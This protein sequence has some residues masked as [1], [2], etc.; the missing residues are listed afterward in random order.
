MD[1]LRNN[2]FLKHF[3]KTLFF[4]IRRVESIPRLK[5]VLN[6][7]TKE[8][9]LNEPRCK[10]SNF[11]ACQV[12]HSV[13]NLYSNPVNSSYSSVS[14]LFQFLHFS[15]FVNG[16]VINLPTKAGGNTMEHQVPNKTR[17]REDKN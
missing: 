6:S 15:V 2:S 1:T 7:Y 10:I 11:V 13:K 4:T 3:K 5:Q 16:N 9:K 12:I 17:T 14:Y 8:H